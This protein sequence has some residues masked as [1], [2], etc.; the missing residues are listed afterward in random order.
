MKKK[1][2]NRN[3]KYYVKQTFTLQKYD[4]LKIILVWYK[5]IQNVYRVVIWTTNVFSSVIVIKVFYFSLLD[6]SS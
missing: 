5:I 1:I 4:E 3:E 6:R 2:K